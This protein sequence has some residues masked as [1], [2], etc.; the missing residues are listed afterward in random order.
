MGLPVAASQSRAVL[1]TLP[2]TMVLP[3][4]LNATAATSV[5]VWPSSV[6]DGLAGG[7]VPEPRR[8]V[9]AAGDEALAVGAERHGDRP[10]PGVAI[11][12]AD[13]LA[14]GGVPEPRRA[15]VAAGE[16]ALAVGAEG[17]A[18]DLALVWPCGWPM[19]LAGGGVPE[20]RRA[21][22]RSPVASALAVGAERHGSR[23]R[24]GAP[25]GSPM[26]W[27]VA[28]SQSRAVLS[29]LAG[30]EPSCRRG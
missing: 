27:P 28:A 13:G 7:G 10:S 9:V 12:V 16:R 11:G 6:A 5:L 18:R 29:S 1:S 17:H 3:S 25:S 15:V 24:P 2:V 20:P 4:G 14:G 8:P 23:P 19:G 30:D 26:G 21:C 22:R